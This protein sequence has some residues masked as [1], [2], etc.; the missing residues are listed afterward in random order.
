MSILDEIF[1][2]DLKTIANGQLAQKLVGVLAGGESL[3]SLRTERV[4][5]F[6]TIVVVGPHEG[7]CFNQDE[8]SF[9]IENFQ[10]LYKERVTKERKTPTP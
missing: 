1:N 5:E 8:V 3:G 10:F 2:V 4:K 9:I 6:I 7:R